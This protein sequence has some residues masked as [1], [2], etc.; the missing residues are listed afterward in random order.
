MKIIKLVK[1]TTDSNQVIIADALASVCRGTAAND[2]DTIH[3]SLNS[4][5]TA[6]N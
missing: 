4:P 5:Y 1:S 2:P 6:T 3:F